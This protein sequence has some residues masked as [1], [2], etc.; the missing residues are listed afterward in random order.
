MWDY[1]V[2]DGQ[3]IT[4]AELCQLCSSFLL[5][6]QAM[7]AYDGEVDRMCIQPD[8]D[9]S[10]ALGLLPMMDLVASLSRIN[11]ETGFGATPSSSAAVFRLGPGS[12]PVA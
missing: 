7:D 9:H 11:P 5:L 4:D 2:A 1:C 10:R 8:G 3:I 6:A 12:P